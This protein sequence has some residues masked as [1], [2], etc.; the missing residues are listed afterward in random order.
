MCICASDGKSESRVNCNVSKNVVEGVN[1]AIYYSLPMLFFS[2]LSFFFSFYVNCGATCQKECLR[3]RWLITFTT[4]ENQNKRDQY[5]CLVVKQT[6]ELNSVSDIRVE[7]IQYKIKVKSYIF[8]YVGIFYSTYG[9]Y[10][11]L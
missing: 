7:Y 10:T 9:R 11:E 8:L 4:A 2:F 3:I 1:F 6:M 5:F